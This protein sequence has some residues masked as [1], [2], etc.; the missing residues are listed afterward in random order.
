MVVVLTLYRSIESAVSGLS[1]EVLRSLNRSERTGWQFLSLK[2][3]ITMREYAEH[4][5]LDHRMA[6]RHLR[7][8]VELGVLRRVGA[9]PSTKYRVV[10]PRS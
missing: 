4:M 7:R 9:G 8:F 6:Q 2:T 3:T 10:R 5:G 1:A